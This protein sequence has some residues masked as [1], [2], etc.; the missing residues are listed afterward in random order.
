MP[1]HQD[2]VKALAELMVHHAFEVSTAI[3][4]HAEWKRR[5]R[6]AVIRG[7]CE[8]GSDEIARD[9]YCPLGRWLHGMP[10]ESRN[11]HVYDDIIEVH[12]RFHRAAS[13]VVQFL[14]AG[15]IDDA[16]AAMDSDSEFAQASEELV[17]LLEDWRAAA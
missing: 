11:D 12:A 17:C 14:E 4:A 6:D 13:D 16:R 10:V 15:R 8:L 5:L 2:M 7:H 3:S 1:K 9:D